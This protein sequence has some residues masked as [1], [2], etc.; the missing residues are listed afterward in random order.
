ME[1][2]SEEPYHTGFEECGRLREFGEEKWLNDIIWAYQFILVEGWKTIES[3]VDCGGPNS[4]GF[5][6]K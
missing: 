3:Y 5:R 1:H 2:Y 6:G 4:R